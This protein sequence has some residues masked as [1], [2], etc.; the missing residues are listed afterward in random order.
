[1]SRATVQV[2]IIARLVRRDKD[3][4]ELESNIVSGAIPA[5]KLEYMLFYERVLVDGRA[6]DLARLEKV[7]PATAHD[8]VT[9]KQ[10]PRQLPL[11][12]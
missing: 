12:K 11:F 1:M 7:A 5:D 9:G 3:L 8:I 6:R 4:A 10:I 2:K